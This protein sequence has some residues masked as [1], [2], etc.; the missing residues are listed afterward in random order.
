MFKTSPH[1]NTSAK[2]LESI[3]LVDTKNA[4]TPSKSFVRTAIEDLFD[5]HLTKRR[6]THDTG[7][8]SDIKG[9]LC[10]RVRSAGE[11]SRRRQR[12]VGKDGINSLKLGM[13]SGLYRS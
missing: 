7:F 2:I 6:G 11:K 12:R 1:I 4:T 10:E 9:S 13:S 3:P 8:D 5:A